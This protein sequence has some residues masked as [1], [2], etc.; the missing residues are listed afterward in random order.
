MQQ[1]ALQRLLASSNNE[2]ARQRF[3]GAFPWILLATREARG[4]QQE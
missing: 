1:A 2:G 4:L 3:M